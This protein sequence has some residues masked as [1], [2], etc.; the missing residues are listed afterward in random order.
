MADVEENLHLLRAGRLTSKLVHDFKNQIGGLKLYAAYLKK[1][2]EDN[3]EGVEI[4][5]KIIEGLNGMAEQATILVRLTRPLE[6]NRVEA[7]FSPVIEG[8][9]ADCQALAGAR[10]VALELIREPGVEK[11]KTELD[12]AHLRAALR[13][14]VERAAAVSPEGG[15]VRVRLGV[16]AGEAVI[17]VEDAGPGQAGAEGLFDPLSADRINKASLELAMAERIIEH[18]R[19]AVVARANGGEGVT[20]TVRLPL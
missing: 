8:A 13:A 18:H 6:L 9:I 19:G 11:I 15:E 14:I 12:G 4:A 7:E 10:K 17:T 1:R 16:S 3:P 20:V 5:D 2:F